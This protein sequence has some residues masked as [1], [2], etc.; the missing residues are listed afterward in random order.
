MRFCKNRGKPISWYIAS[1]RAGNSSS[2]Y[3]TFQDLSHYEFKAMHPSRPWN[4]MKRL[5]HV[6]SNQSFS[7]WGGWITDPFEWDSGRSLMLV[8]D[9]LGS[10]FGYVFPLNLVAWS[11][12]RWFLEEL[13]RYPTRKGRKVRSGFNWS[14][15]RHPIHFFTILYIYTYD[16]YIYIHIYIYMTHIY[17]Y[18]YICEGFAVWN[19]HFSSEVDTWWRSCCPDVG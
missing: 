9:G 15:H 5:H 2:V 17:M 12:F 14:Y 11:R 1:N 19:I 13:W 3:V 8:D 16:I 7:P 18:M 6:A 4:V 10:V